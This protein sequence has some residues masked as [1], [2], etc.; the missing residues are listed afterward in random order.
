MMHTISRVVAGSRAGSARTRTLLG[1]L[2]LLAATTAFAQ[3]TTAPAD[4]PG[5]KPAV[6]RASCVLGIESTAPRY[7]GQSNSIVPTVQAM[8]SSTALLDPAMESILKLSSTEWPKVAQVDVIPAGDSA[9]KVTVFVKSNAGQTYPPTTAA[10]L[11]REIAERAVRACN[12]PERPDESAAKIEALVKE[13]NQLDVRLAE[14]RVELARANEAANSPRDYNSRLMNRLPLEQQVAQSEMDRA[15][16]E[17]VLVEI[18]VQLKEL[19]ASPAVADLKELRVKLIGQRIDGRISLAREKTRLEILRKRLDELEKP[20][21][22]SKPARSYQE[23]QMEQSEL[24]N[25]R[26]RIEQDIAR[27]ESAKTNLPSKP[28]LAI[29][30]GSPR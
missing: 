5:D 20:A 2:A 7:G 9:V 8:L 1:A 15:T 26:S 24:M 11:L 29:L 19:E 18:D 30:D 27:I 4:R 16:L 17:V 10:T 12:A 21:A 28:R 3:P 22:T 25:R 13:R 14:I 23:V 6:Q